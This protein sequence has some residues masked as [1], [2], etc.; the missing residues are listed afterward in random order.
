MHPAFVAQVVSK[1]ESRFGR[2]RFAVLSPRKDRRGY[3]LFWESDGGNVPDAES[4]ESLLG[5]NYHYAHA[6]NMRQMEPVEV[7]VVEDGIGLWCRAAK[8]PRASAKPPPLL[9]FSSVVMDGS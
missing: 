3:R 7:V 5:D 1:L 9:P 8:V 4:V 6:V 2:S